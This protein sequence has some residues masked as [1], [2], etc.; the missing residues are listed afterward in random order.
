[1]ISTLSKTD[2]ERLGC[3]DLPGPALRRKVFGLQ[4]LVGQVAF[5]LQQVLDDLVKHGHVETGTV[6]DIGEALLQFKSDHAKELM[7]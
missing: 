2:F 3:E 1:M 6:E 4:G 7:S 5:V